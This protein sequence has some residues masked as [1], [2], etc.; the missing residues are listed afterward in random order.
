[1]DG[2]ITCSNFVAFKGN[3]A[4]YVVD[5]GLLT[6]KG[7]SFMGNTID[8][9]ADERSVTLEGCWFSGEAAS[10]D[11]IISSTGVTTGEG[12]STVEIDVDAGTA[13]CPWPLIPMPTP[14]GIEAQPTTS[15]PTASASARCLDSPVFQ[16]SF[17]LRTAV[18]QPTN[19]FAASRRHCDSSVYVA[20]PDLDRTVE[21][22]VSD[23]LVQSATI[24]LTTRVQPSSF[25]LRSNPFT[26][27]RA[28]NA[29]HDFIGPSSQVNP[30]SLLLPPEAQ[31]Q[32][33]QLKQTSELCGSAMIDET[34][35]L[36]TFLFVKSLTITDS[37]QFGDSSGIAGSFQ[38]FRTDCLL[39]SIQIAVTDAVEHSSHFLLTQYNSAS[40]E[41][42][43]TNSMWTDGFQQS[44]K[45]PPTAIGQTFH[46]LLSSPL[47]VAPNSVRHLDGTQNDTI[48][49]S[50]RFSD[51][52]MGTFNA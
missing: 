44:A 33:A 36:S 1:M 28:C 45:L 35:L 46:F 24:G 52:K 48:A 43:G 29:T 27:T 22:D 17:P 14:D 47:M 2:M 4:V 51:A 19:H 18:A 9:Q 34:P 39:H 16:H 21:I 49:R 23:H 3:E 6:L 37:G 11:L 38:S 25:V 13:H 8:V 42:N 12:G 20:T 7:C 41:M 30:S 10:D 50:R 32:T 26:D 15:I 31:C 40:S 5:D